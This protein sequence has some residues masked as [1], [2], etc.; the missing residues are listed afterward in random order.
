[1]QCL[2]ANKG[3][4][5]DLSKTGNVTS[6]E[7]NELDTSAGRKPSMTKPE[8]PC[9]G[10]NEEGSP[11][12]TKPELLKS[13]QSPKRVNEQVILILNYHSQFVIDL[14]IYSDWLIMIDD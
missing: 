9:A 8:N 13:G 11:K 10:Q 1:M 14:T 5:R 12:E 4:L 3:T 6:L 2:W 7:Q